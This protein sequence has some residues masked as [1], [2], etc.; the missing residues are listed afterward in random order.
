MNDSSELL[1]GYNFARKILREKLIRIKEEQEPDN[2]SELVSSY[3]LLSF[4]TLRDSLTMWRL[5]SAN[6]TGVS[7]CFDVNVIRQYCD[8]DF[9][10]C[11]Y[12][13]KQVQQRIDECL[14]GLEPVSE[15][16]TDLV[17]AVII[18]LLFAY[19]FG[20]NDTIE[21]VIFPYFKF[22]SS[23]KNEAY[24]D[25]KEVRLVRVAEQSDMKFRFRNNKIVPYVEQF[26][27]KEALT[28]IIV[29]PNNDMSRTIYSIQTYLKH[30]GFDHVKVTPSEVPY[31]D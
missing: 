24:A 4:S 27:P 21:E 20:K 11:V 6:A 19:M 28:E 10:R 12:L 18:A 25:E 13:S 2:L 23:L 16:T 30:I 26:F 29:G 9:M 31:R 15:N 17:T 14:A 8:V 22:V 3:Y 5:Y 1:T 7:L